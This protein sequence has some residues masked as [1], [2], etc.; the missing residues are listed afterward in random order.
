[1]S[2]VGC[3]VLNGQVPPRIIMNDD[4]CSGQVQSCAAGFERNQEDGKLYDESKINTAL[5]Y[6]KAE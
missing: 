1:M 4:I 5:L 2:T 3:L 6:W